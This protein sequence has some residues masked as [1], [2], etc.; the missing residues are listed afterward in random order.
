MLNL[1]GNEIHHKLLEL[2]TMDYFDR[3][4]IGVTISQI[5]NAWPK[6]IDITMNGCRSNYPHT[7]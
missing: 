1:T 6:L 4:P 3:K 5:Q 7:I 2:K